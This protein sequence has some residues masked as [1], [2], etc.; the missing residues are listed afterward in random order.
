MIAG[1]ITMMK[2]NT[3]AEM[4]EKE[5][6]LKC[7]KHSNYAVNTL[8]NKYGFTMSQLQEIKENAALLQTSK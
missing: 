4:T 6:L 3:G 8:I 2:Y 1:L 7:I 5:L